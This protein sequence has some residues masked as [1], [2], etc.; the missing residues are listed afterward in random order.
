MW[1]DTAPMLSF[2][3]GMMGATVVLPTTN[4]V[5]K[6]TTTIYTA[7]CC[8][9]T[10]V[11]PVFTTNTFR[12]RKTTIASIE[13]LAASF[14]IKTF[15]FVIWASNGL[16]SLNVIF[17]WCLYILQNI[18]QVIWGCFKIENYINY[19][20]FLISSLLLWREERYSG[21]SSKR[22]LCK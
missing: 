5:R 10:T 7:C 8:M 11:N 15:T 6:R 13:K 18:L 20:N 9:G 2:T 22:T 4:S 1:P 19:Q 16:N 12:N 3:L 21:L 17:N 14:S